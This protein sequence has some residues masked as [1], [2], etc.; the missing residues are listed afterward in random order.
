MP[1]SSD[2]LKYLRDVGKAVKDLRS[3]AGMSQEA[4]A[5]LTGLHRTYI[6]SLE[7]GERNVSIL[8]IRLLA[9]ALDVSAGT[10][11][12]AKRKK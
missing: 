5:D 6:G 7:R 2:Q 4:L 1:Y 8:N 9:N 10:L 3:K 11:T 12:D